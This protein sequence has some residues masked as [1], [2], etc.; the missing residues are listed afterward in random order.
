MTSMSS[1]HLHSR[2]NGTKRGL[3]QSIR[4]SVTR[5]PLSLP[6]SSSAS[7]APKA[8]MSEV[9]RAAFLALETADREKAARAGAGAG[10]TLTPTGTTAAR[11]PTDDSPAL[12]SLPHKRARRVVPRKVNLSDTSI[13]KAELQTLRAFNIGQVGNIDINATMR[14]F[15]RTVSHGDQ[16]GATGLLDMARVIISL[17]HN[18]VCALL[19]EGLLTLFACVL[20]APETSPAVAESFLRALHS[21]PIRAYHVNVLLRDELTSYC[22]IRN[23]PLIQELGLRENVSGSTVIEAVMYSCKRALGHDKGARGGGS[24]DSVHTPR[25]HSWTR[26]LKLANRVLKHSFAWE[27]SFVRGAAANELLARITKLK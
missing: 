10:A 8:F 14:S 5:H 21:L 9:A 7:A 15:L 19:D 16:T 23:P 26:C 20:G 24:S 11:S 1:T 2:R 13:P 6:S 3:A 27:C 22:K 12:L 18:H 25:S 4:T 17:P